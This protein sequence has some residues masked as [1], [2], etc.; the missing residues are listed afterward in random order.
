M[1]DALKVLGLFIEAKEEIFRKH[2]CNVLQ[3]AKMILESTVL[4]QDTVEEGS[5][6]F[7]KEAYHSLVMIEKTL[8]QFPDL[9]FGKDFEVMLSA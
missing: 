5:N 9:T 8:Q 7:W 1:L 3:E 4:L 6:P 2:I